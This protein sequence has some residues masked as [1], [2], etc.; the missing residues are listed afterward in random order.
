MP[1][2][3]RAR[4]SCRPVAYTTSAR[5]RSSVSPWAAEKVMFWLILP[6]C[7]QAVCGTAGQP[8]L[9]LHRR[10]RT[11]HMPRF[12][13]IAPFPH[14]PYESRRSDRSAE[15][16]FR[17]QPCQCSRRDSLPVSACVL[18]PMFPIQAAHRG[19]FAIQLQRDRRVASPRV[20]CSRTLHASQPRC[21][22]HPSISMKAAFPTLP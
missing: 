7:T 20:P 4:S 19:E 9:M 10:S 6:D 1:S 8:E 13:Q 3:I 22:Q 14:Q 2:A 21:P 15:S 17:W 5:R 11:Y 12:R 18:S 16:S